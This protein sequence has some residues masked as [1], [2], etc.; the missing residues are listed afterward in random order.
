[1][2]LPLP[3]SARMKVVTC[4]AIAIPYPTA[5]DIDS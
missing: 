3:Q 2:I 4:I 1:M 5:V